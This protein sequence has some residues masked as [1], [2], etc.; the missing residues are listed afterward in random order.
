MY[1]VSE[2]RVGHIRPRATLRA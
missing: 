1:L 2:G